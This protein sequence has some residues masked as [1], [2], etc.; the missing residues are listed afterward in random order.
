MKRLFIPPVL[1]FISLLLIILFYFVIPGYNTIPFPYNLSGLVIA[2]IGFTIMGKARDLYRK[3]GTTLAFDRSSHLIDEGIFR[4]TRNP[5]Y[6]GM[7]LLLFG[8]GVFSTNIFSLLTSLVFLG[9]IH[10]YFIPL[11]EK[12]MHE[13]FGQEYL[14][15]KKKVRRWF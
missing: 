1:L 13:S 6:I 4:K 10:L 3:Y 12:L 7:F 8:L 11:E 9:L 5:M 15:Y 2:V 14:V